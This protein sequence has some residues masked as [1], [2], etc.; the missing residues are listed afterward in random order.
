MTGPGAFW[1]S[2]APAAALSATGATT[3][4]PGVGAQTW[5]GLAPFAGSS[6]TLTPGVGAQTWTGIAPTVAIAVVVAPGVG[7]QT[8]TGIAPTVLTPRLLL[9]GVGAQTWTGLAPIAQVSIS[10]LP[11]VGAQ[12]W[13]GLAPSVV[14][15]N[16]ISVTPGVGAQIW[17]GL[18]PV[19]TGVVVTSVPAVGGR[20][21]HHAQPP[22]R[23]RRSELPYVELASDEVCT[24]GTGRVVYRGLKP[25]V[26]VSNVEAEDRFALDLVMDDE[27]ITLA[28]TLAD[29]WMT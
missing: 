29:A 15:T 28:L 8:W 4:L 3:V 13:A 18:A 12:A 5:A 21:R 17:T 26:M 22:P 7:A 6:A 27:D 24:P 16:N 10:V 19:I 2:G 9:P 14:T 23:R 1:Y 20:P 11:G 25:R